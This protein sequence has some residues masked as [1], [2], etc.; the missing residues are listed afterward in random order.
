MPVV[1][2]TLGWPEE[3]LATRAG[4]SEPR[5][6]AAVAAYGGA[7]AANLAK[8]KTCSTVWVMLKTAVAK[9]ASSRYRN[10]VRIMLIEA[11]YN[12]YLQ[13]QRTRSGQE[14]WKG[15]GLVWERPTH[16]Q[17]RRRRKEHAQGIESGVTAARKG[18]AAGS[19][20]RG[21]ESSR[22]RPVDGTLCGARGVA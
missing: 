14:R 6:P 7:P 1:G 10:A 17:E 3:G 19:R 8:D 21:L 20:R 11:T 22:H 9:L 2:R 4:C 12:L 18:A 16:D 15:R 5:G 13:L